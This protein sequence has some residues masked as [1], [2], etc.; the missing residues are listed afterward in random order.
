[1]AFLEKHPRAF[2]A[3]VRQQNQ[4]WKQAALDIHLIPVYNTPILKD[5]GFLAR[6]L[7]SAAP[8][9]VEYE[10]TA[11]GRALLP[12]LDALSAWATHWLGRK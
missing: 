6:R 4:I 2:P 1:M 5:Q 12:V 8:A 3:R 7:V 9:H 11:K 10:L